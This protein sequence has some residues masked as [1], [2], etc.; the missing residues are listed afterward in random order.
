M[1]GLGPWGKEFLPLN[2]GPT[3]Y[4]VHLCPPLSQAERARGSFAKTSHNTFYLVRFPVV[5][6]LISL[7]VTA[8][9]K[10]TAF[11]KGTAYVTLGIEREKHG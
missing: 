9:L 8:S 1:L 7:K 2:R 11:L 5:Y 4:F 10:G 6:L 3:V